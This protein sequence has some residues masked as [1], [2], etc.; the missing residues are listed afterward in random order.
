MSN[1]ITKLQD[2]GE[3]AQQLLG[4]IQECKPDANLESLAEKI[5]NWKLNKNIKEDSKNTFS[6][7][8]NG[9]VFDHKAG[10]MWKRQCERNKYTFNEAIKRFKGNDTFAGYNDWRL[11][12]IDELKT[13]L[14][15]NPPY[16]DTEAFP[17]NP[18]NVWSGSPYAGNA[19][20]AW[21]VNFYGGYS[22]SSL[23]PNVSNGVRLVRGGQ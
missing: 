2:M 1:N 23:F 19:S 7:Q 6:I 5:Q 10:L 12:T 17:D 16:I 21:Y 11:P 20:G 4:L 3:H 22:G 18:S 15:K 8:S 13:L 14:L 9:T